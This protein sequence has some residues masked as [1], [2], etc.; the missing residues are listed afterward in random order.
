MGTGLKIRYGWIKYKGNGFEELPQEISRAFERLALPCIVY[1]GQGY[2]THF[3]SR[4]VVGPTPIYYVYQVHAVRAVAKANPVIAHYLNHI[5]YPKY[6]TALF[7]F[8]PHEVVVLDEPMHFFDFPAGY[9]DWN[10]IS[11]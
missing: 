2:G 4:R 7:G 3:V 6:E 8:F 1:H 9:W 5:G 11:D 10:K